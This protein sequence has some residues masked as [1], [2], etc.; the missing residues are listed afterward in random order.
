M[1]HILT[2]A[3]LLAAPESAIAVGLLY[4]ALGIWG[5]AL[6]DQRAIAAVIGRGTATDVLGI[7]FGLALVVAWRAPL[8][9]PSHPET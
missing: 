1:V 2:G 4:L 8:R 3:L 5:S 6:G 9:P 7:I